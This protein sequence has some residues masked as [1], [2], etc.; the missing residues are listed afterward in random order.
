VLQ[1]AHSG[2]YLLSN[3]HTNRNANDEPNAPW[4]FP[5]VILMHLAIERCMTEQMMAQ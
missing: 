1:F 4:P 2:G 5:P 3:K